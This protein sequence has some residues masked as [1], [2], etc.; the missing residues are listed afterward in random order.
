MSVLVRR[1][2]G[3]WGPEGERKSFIARREC[4]CCL[5]LLDE[6][7]NKDGSWNGYTPPTVLALLALGAMG[8][9]SQDDRLVRGLA[10][11][12]RQKI[13]DEHGLHFLPF[14]STTWTSAY[15][16]RALLCAG[17][18]TASPQMQKA[19]AWFVDHQH[20]APQAPLN[21]R[22]PGAP[23][24]GGW[25]FGGTNPTMQDCD[26]TAAVLSALGLADQQT[27]GVV[28]DS[29]R[30]TVR[31][32][33][34]WLLGMQNADGG[35]A[36]F[37]HG[38]PGKPPGPI[39]TQ[40]LHM[41]LR[42]LW[43]GIRLCC[44]PPVELGDPST[45]DVTGR[46]L[47]ALGMNGF[48]IGHPHVV[49]AVA[50]LK[51]QQCAN[52]AWW[53]RWMVNYVPTTAFV[54]L[55]LAAVRA[56]L[57]A[58][59][60]RRAVTWLLEHQNPDGGW[61]ES[62]ASYRD[63][64]LAGLGP[65]MPPV[66]ALVVS[67]LVD[68]GE[69]F[70]AAVT[71]GVRYLLDQQRV[72]GTW[73]DAGSLHC[74]LPPDT[75]YTFPA[76]ALSYPTEALARC[77]KLYEG[78][79]R[80]SGGSPAPTERWDDAT[81]DRFRGEGDPE[82]DAAVQVLLAGDR[83]SALPVLLGQAFSLKEGT[84]QLP[85]LQTYLERTAA[86]PPWADTEKIARAQRLF[87]RYGWEVAL[88][89]FCSSLPQ[90]YAA[91]PCARLLVRSQAMT[92]HVRQRIFET[93]QFLFD[94]ME[95]GALRPGGPGVRSAQKVRLLHAIL[96]LVHQPGPQNETNEV[97]INQEDM[98]GALLTFSCVTFD[99][100][101][102]LWKFEAAE[103]EAWL[104]AWTVVGH[105]LG[106][107]AELLP[108]TL[109]EAET[110]M[111]AFRR[112]QWASS[113]EGKELARALVALMQEYYPPA[114]A[115]VPVLLIRLFAGDHCADLLGLPAERPPAWL[116]WLRPQRRSERAGLAHPL[117]GLIRQAAHL[118]MKRIV[119]AENGAQ[120]LRFRV[121]TTLLRA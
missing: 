115:G 101:R 104:H 74:L 71:A 14:V 103:G 17:E 51:H 68:V 84:P 31:R 37:V 102:R 6:Y 56:D 96:R 60:V 121:P 79:N 28:A 54:L 90:G 3:D 57:N 93:A 41:P 69:G 118:L 20:H 62:E 105:L 15:S 72:D 87:A 76:L 55:G 98:A 5:E 29:L 36:T 25:S 13:T 100:L 4:R 77:L 106:I 107:R 23:R 46:V 65:S 73:S 52:G 75:F 40:S 10:W 108:H 113:P 16:T 99:V 33:C 89:L 67:A 45:E 8:L 112:R 34:D 120:P 42:S 78:A 80:S 119:H 26:D 88:A 114:L 66:T 27:H 48:T 2:R 92:R 1:L 116:G 35:W 83:G 94:V 59:W 38:L 58:P 110:L 111:E 85:A 24:S 86:L 9:P 109:G 39:M 7:Q 30:E 81:L 61:G 53:G 82:A 47:H 32:G 63:P 49:Q 97:L 18:K 50:F 43:A 21:Q 117:A 64:A 70:S 19:L 22:R 44:K 91:A 11:L 12:E 95:E